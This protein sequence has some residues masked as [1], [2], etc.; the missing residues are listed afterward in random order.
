MAVTVLVRKPVQLTGT[1]IEMLRFL[2]D[3]REAPPVQWRPGTYDVL[4]ANGLIERRGR[5]SRYRST[6][7]GDDVLSQL[8]EGGDALTA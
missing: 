7:V 4:E 5:P 8:A 3:E 1:Q 6:R 2:A